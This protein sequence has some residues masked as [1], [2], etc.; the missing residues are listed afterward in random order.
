MKCDERLGGCSNCERLQLKCPGN[1]AG[2]LPP[3]Q[4]LK[5]PPQAGVK[6][7]KTY[8]SCA[9]CR[10]SKTRCSGDR[11]VCLRCSRKHIECIYDSDP[12]PAWARAV[13]RDSLNSTTSE[14]QEQTLDADLDERLNEHQPRSRRSTFEPENESS[15]GSFSDP[16]S[17]AGWD[18][19]AWQVQSPLHI[20]L[21]ELIN[22]AGCKLLISRTR[23]DCSA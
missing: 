23:R 11:P 13:F 22:S 15:S 5:L 14:Q 8:R 12:D 9:Q 19:I 2:Q 21:G 3:V 16:R 17:G 20:G 4:D 6:R 10:A 18:T 1:D 7:K